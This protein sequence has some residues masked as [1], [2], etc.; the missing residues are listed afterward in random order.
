[1]VY[2]EVFAYTW[3]G[4]SLAFGFVD[5]GFFVVLFCLSCFRFGVFC[6]QVLVAVVF[7]W[8]RCL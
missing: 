6:G 7:V 4:L 5:W 8:D 2:S 1:M 3:G